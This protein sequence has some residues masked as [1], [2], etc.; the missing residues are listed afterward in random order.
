MKKKIT[1][2]EMSCTKHE[3]GRSI[4]PCIENMH[5]SMWCLRAWAPTKSIMRS[6]GVVRGECIIDSW[7][8]AYLLTS[9][10]EN[11][12][13]CKCVW[14]VNKIRENIFLQNKT[15]MKA[16]PFKVSAAI[17]RA[18]ISIFTSSRGKLRLSTDEQFVSADFDTSFI[19]I[20]IYGHLKACGSSF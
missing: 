1:D 13:L 4:C 9:Q 7:Y 3:E 6:L 2:F 11:K 15:H 17:L 19:E 14:I 12:S 20:Q 10:S 8:F 18:Q 16:E 5:E